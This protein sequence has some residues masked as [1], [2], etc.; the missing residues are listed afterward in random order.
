[1]TRHS[2]GIAL[3]ALLAAPAAAYGLPPFSTDPKSAGPDDGG[4]TELSGVSVACHKRFDRFVVTAHDVTPAAYRARYVK[5]IIADGSGDVVAL[6]GRKRIRLLFPTARAHRESD[7]APLVPRVVTPLCPNL[8]QVKLAGDF[9]GVVTFGFGLRAKTGFRVF[10][11]T[12][13]DRVVLDVH[14]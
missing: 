5:R 7:G 8:R 9:E 3:A 11:L 13:P 4:Q 1:M 2:I 6:R 14:H 12:A 10:R